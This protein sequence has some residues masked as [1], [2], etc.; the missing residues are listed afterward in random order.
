MSAI[1]D[2]YTSIGVAR[3]RRKGMGVMP[4]LSREIRKAK[5]EERKT[6]NEKRKQR[7]RTTP[8]SWLNKQGNPSK[9]WEKR[10]TAYS[11]PNHAQSAR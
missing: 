5:N 3:R 2:V 11:T 4:T 6:R 8:A 1:L 10:T 7:Q 9:Y